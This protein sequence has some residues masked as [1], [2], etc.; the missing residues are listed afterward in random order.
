MCIY[1]DFVRS[2]FLLPETLG[3][4]S[5]L[6]EHSYAYMKEDQVCVENSIT[7]H[8]VMLSVNHDIVTSFVDIIKSLIFS[9]PEKGGKIFLTHIKRFLLDNAS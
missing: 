9:Y 7:W 8:F 4:I 1:A 3:Y 6:N 5:E 2:G